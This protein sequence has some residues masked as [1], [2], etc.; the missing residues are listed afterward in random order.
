MLM[1]KL[2]SSSNFSSQ[3]FDFRMFQLPT[4]QL[5][6][7]HVWPLLCNLQMAKFTSV[8]P[9]AFQQICMSFYS[10]LDISNKCSEAPPSHSV[11]CAG[12][13]VFGWGELMFALCPWVIVH[14]WAARTSSVGASLHLECVQ[15]QKVTWKT[16]LAEA[17][18]AA[19]VQWSPGPRHVST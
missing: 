1:L 7:T 19:V 12:F 9:S 17:E 16:T 8:F 6:V 11:C 18:H 3:K 13:R 14:W 4:P 2:V 10:Y 15:I 5:N